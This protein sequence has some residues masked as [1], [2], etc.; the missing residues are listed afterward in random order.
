MRRIIL[1]WAD[2]DWQP[3]IGRRIVDE[4]LLSLEADHWD[5]P[6]VVELTGGLDGIVIEPALT[7]SDAATPPILI[8][9]DW[10]IGKVLS[11]S[12]E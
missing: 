9:K 2:A 4:L 1:T 8:E 12:G 11:G 3:G 6:D 5:V 10:R 7:G